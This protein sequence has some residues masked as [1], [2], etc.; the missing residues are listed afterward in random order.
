MRRRI[1]SVLEQTFQDYE[2]LFL[3]DASS[4]GSAEVFA[5]FSQHPKLRA[6]LNTENSGSPFAQWNRGV[7]EARGEFV[8]IAEAD[9]YSD[10]NFLATLVEK[11]EAHPS[12]GIAYCQSVI[13]D[14]SDRVV[15]RF[16]LEL[17]GKREAWLSD[18]VESG[19]KICERY[20]LNENYIINASAVVFRKDVYVGAGYAEETMRLCGDWLTYAK[21]LAI[22][23]LVYSA[24]PYN[25]FRTHS[26][27]VRRTT[28]TLRAARELAMVQSFIRANTGPTER[29]RRE[30]LANFRRWMATFGARDRGK[31]WQESI[32]AFLSRRALDYAGLKTM[33]RARI[34]PDAARRRPSGRHA[35]GDASMAKLMAAQKLFN[36]WYL[37]G[38][39]LFFLMLF[40]PTSYVPV[41]AALM[42]IV[43]ASILLNA[44]LDKRVTLHVYVVAATVFM[45]VI[46]FLFVILGLFNGNPG[47]ITSLPVY[48]LWPLLYLVFV[49]GCVRLDILTGLMRTLVVSTVAIALYSLS[50]VLNEAHLLPSFLYF[51]LDLGQKIGITR[52]TFSTPCI[53]SRL[54][55]PRSV[56]SGGAYL[57]ARSGPG[58]PVSRRWLWVAFLSTGP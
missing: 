8:W 7:R 47:A 10:P 30:N 33:T 56:P 52:A 3:D 57:V 11:L 53:R 44:F 36:V 43:L 58:P 12:A 46:G 48:V 2:I 19:R 22:S 5:E 40:A 24:S 23:D 26:S 14:E 42:A 29:E 55:L 6:I 50:Y 16:P 34:R 39:L 17:S 9:D 31:P 18:F 28:P 20:M 38:Y 4:D 13:V 25:Y 1:L 37:P 35:R 41:K 49:M 21:M 54:Y 27:T 45:C 15:A 32:P 51:K